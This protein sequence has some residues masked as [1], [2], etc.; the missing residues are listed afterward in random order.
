[1]IKTGTH[2][3]LKILLSIVFI[4]AIFT[5]CKKEKETIAIIKVEYPDGSPMKGA[6][7][8]LDQTNG[9]PGT[10]P[11]EDLRK[12]KETD[13]SGEAEF[14]YAY[15]AILDVTV[16]KES[17]NDIYLG[18]TVIKL[19]KGETTTKTVETVLQ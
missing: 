4:A 2:K 6:T 8:E 9:A 19:V 7:V 3:I 1:M 16:T 10:D 5:S 12:E 14:I 13:A 11:I 15:E 18:S 17:G